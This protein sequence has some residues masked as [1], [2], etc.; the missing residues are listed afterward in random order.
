MENNFKRCPIQPI[1]GAG[2]L[3]ESCQRRIIPDP[4]RTR[5]KEDHKINP[6]CI[7]LYKPQRRLVDG[8]WQDIYPIIERTTPDG[9][10]IT[11]DLLKENYL[12]T[13]FQETCNLYRNELNP[14]TQ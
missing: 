10:P 8:K 11:T 12:D 7:P 14:P 6:V 13:K 9:K 4:C 3:C 2:I 1:P 5:L